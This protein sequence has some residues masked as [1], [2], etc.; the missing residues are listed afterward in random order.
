MRGETGFWRVPGV[1][2]RQCSVKVNLGLLRTEETAFA[3]WSVTIFPS[4]VPSRASQL[5][6][7]VSGGAVLGTEQGSVLVTPP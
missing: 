5:Q 7:P 3:N 6:P 2:R 4:A 1:H